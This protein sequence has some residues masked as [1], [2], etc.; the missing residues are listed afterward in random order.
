MTHYSSA[1]TSCHSAPPPQLRNPR[2]SSQTLI[3]NNDL[4]QQLKS[5]VSN[6]H[7]TDAVY[8]IHQNRL[9]GELVTV[10]HINVEHSPPQDNMSRFSPLDASV[11]SLF[12]EDPYT[13]AAIN[14]GRTAPIQLLN[15]VD[16]DVRLPS[17]RSALSSSMNISRDNR[18]KEPP[19]CH[20]PPGVANLLLSTSLDSGILPDQR[21]LTQSSDERGNSDTSAQQSYSR[22][23]LQLKLVPANTKLVPANTNRSLTAKH[24]PKLLEANTN[25]A[26]NKIA[27]NISNI[28]K[29]SNINII[30]KKVC[31]KETNKYDKKMCGSNVFNN[32]QNPNNTKNSKKIS[33]KPTTY[34]QSKKKTVKSKHGML[35]CLETERINE[36]N[37]DDDLVQSS[38]TLSENR[39]SETSAPLPNPTVQQS[40][41]NMQLSGEQAGQQLSDDKFVDQMSDEKIKHELDGD[42]IVHHVSGAKTTY[43]VSGAKTTYQVSSAKTI[44][45][46]TADSSS[47][48][49]YPSLSELNFSSLAAQKILRGVS[50]NSIDTLM[51]VNIAARDKSIKISEPVTNTDFGYL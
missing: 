22:A 32:L 23:G 46:V 42:K 15:V 5:G 25:I 1:H 45:P 43:Q 28:E 3:Y 29:R 49:T 9:N 16:A 20:K 34:H 6:D 12:I 14:S 33:L 51:E 24:P 27:S 50:I 8:N 30:P 41:K 44:H 7:Q 21:S 39:I 19:S 37:Q 11:P 17:T 18:N 35:K 31:C 2:C 40:L 13:T 47:V 36:K 4:H 26:N 10:K 48:R 38:N